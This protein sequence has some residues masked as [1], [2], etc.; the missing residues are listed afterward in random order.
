M[1]KGIAPL[2]Q[3]VSP[4]RTIRAGSGPCGEPLTGIAGDASASAMFTKLRARAAIAPILGHSVFIK[5]AV[6]NERNRLWAGEGA[7]ASRS[8][9]PVDMF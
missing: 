7:R 4:I 5:L 1:V 3:I 6:I 8:A 2:D 9:R